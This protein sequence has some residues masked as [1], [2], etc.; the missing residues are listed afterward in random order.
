MNKE[1]ANIR[2]K[3]KAGNLNSYDRK[4]YVCKII[5]MYILGY[6]AEIGFSEAM[7]LCAGTK[8]SEKQIVWSICFPSKCC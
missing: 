3:F 5:Y 8:Y 6:S 1:L 2:S 4:K 7:S